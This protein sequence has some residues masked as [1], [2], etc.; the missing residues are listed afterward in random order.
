MKY[1]SRNVRNQKKSAF[2]IAVVIILIITFLFSILAMVF[3]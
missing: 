1:F 2:V 3:V